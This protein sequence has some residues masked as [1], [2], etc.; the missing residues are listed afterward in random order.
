MAVLIIGTGRDEIDLPTP[1]E[2]SVTLQDIDSG[3]TTRNAKGY[4][5]R[6]RVRGE[7]KVVR[8]IECTWKGMEMD[9]ASY[10]MRVVSPVFFELTYPDTYTGEMRTGTFYVGDRK[11]TFMKVDH[12]GAHALMSTVTINF[13]EK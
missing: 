6:D 4:M 11:C 1:S 7:E 9:D 3:S 2:M 12:D 8:K 13:I 5:L 10:L